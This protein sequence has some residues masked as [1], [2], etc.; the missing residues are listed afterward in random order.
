MTWVRYSTS[1]GFVLGDPAL[2]PRPNGLPSSTRQ[3]LQLVTR[4]CACGCSRT[5]RCM[6][7]SPSR[8][9]SLYC[10]GRAARQ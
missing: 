5:F 2:N 9:A 10:A 3:P 6:P 1:R 4:S 7:T 8:Y